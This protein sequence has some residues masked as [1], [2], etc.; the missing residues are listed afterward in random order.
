MDRQGKEKLRTVFAEIFNGAEASII[1]EYRGLTVEEL[2]EL[3]RSL[4][5]IQGRFRVLKNRVAK[6]AL[7]DEAKEY[8]SLSD[9]LKGPVGVA[10]FK[11]DPA[12]AAKSVLKFAEDH[13]NF[14][15]KNAVVGNAVMSQSELKALSDLPSREVL[16]GKVVGSLISPHRGLMYALNGVSSNLVRVINAIKDSKQG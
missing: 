4:R 15:V 13:P 11:G 14:I 9:A 5:P 1:A 16:L 6:K 7:A 10:Y 12:Q 8:G 2:T 3:R